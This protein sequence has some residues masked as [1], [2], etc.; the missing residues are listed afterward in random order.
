MKVP[1]HIEPEVL[2]W[3]CPKCG[4]EIKSLYFR[5]LDANRRFHLVKHGVLEPEAA[6]W[7]EKTA[8]KYREFSEKL[9]VPKKGEEVK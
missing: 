1:K 4:K 7:L 3:V 5:Q 8:E 6:R 2:R 9:S